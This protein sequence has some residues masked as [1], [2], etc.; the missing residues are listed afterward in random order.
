MSVRI[1]VDAS[2]NVLHVL[3]EGESFATSRESDDGG[4]VFHFNRAGEIVGALVMGAIRTPRDVW[5]T[6]RERAQLPTDVRQALDDWFD[7]PPGQ[8]VER[9][10]LLAPGS[11]RPD[12]HAALVRGGDLPH[13][14]P[15]LP[16]EQL[17][18]GE[19][20]R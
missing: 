17:E 13:A 2:S 10:A 12:D 7:M 3:R 19:V 6:F 8:R 9:F 16:R 1:S 20:R 18:R 15:P 14:D 4:F 5:D 11:S